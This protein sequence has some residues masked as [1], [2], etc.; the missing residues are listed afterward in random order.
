MHNNNVCVFACMHVC[1]SLV[2]DKQQKQHRK[3]L[4]NCMRPCTYSL[5]ILLGSGLYK[6]IH[7]HLSML[8][9]P[10]KNYPLKPAFS[11]AEALHL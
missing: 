3:H 10:E 7:H 2:A 1:G 8:Y 4:D 11:M 5:L 6:V 9:H